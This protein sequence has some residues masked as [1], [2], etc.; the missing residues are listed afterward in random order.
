M[1]NA[2]KK[3]SSNI[4]IYP[5]FSNEKLYKIF[6][7][8]T[9]NHQNGVYIIY[10]GYM[11]WAIYYIIIFDFQIVKF[12]NIQFINTINT[13]IEQIH[14]NRGKEEKIENVEKGMR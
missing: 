12:F 13:Q 4:D 11:K 5:G 2:S 9:A 1:Y 10:F 7:L 3:I 14:K 6:F 8:K